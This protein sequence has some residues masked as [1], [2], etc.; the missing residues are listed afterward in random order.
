MTGR[1][2]DE[3]WR[4]DALLPTLVVV[5]PY[6]FNKLIYIEVPGYPVFVFTDYAC[7]IFSLALLYLLLRCEPPSLPI[8]WRFDVP[9][10]KELLTAVIGTITLIGANVVSA[11]FIRYLNAHGWPATSFPLPT[12]A[13]L[14]YFDGTV[15]MV[16]V[17]LSEEVVFRFYLI[18][19]LLLRGLPTTTAIIVSTLIFGGSH[20]SYGGGIVVFATFAGLVLSMIFLSKRNLI[21]PVIAHVAYDAFYF[22][23]G[24]TFLWRIYNRAW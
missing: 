22:A 16:L 4:P 17:G 20:W 10:T 8:S 3:W 24:V 23:G 6:F 11:T 1:H 15:G 9:S 18:N 13:A 5:G 21:V 19:L 12:N 7:R 14:Q 2:S